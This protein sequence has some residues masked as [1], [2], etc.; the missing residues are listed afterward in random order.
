MLQLKINQIITSFLRFPS[1][2]Q[3]TEIILIWLLFALTILSLGFAF[4]FLE[5]KIADPPKGFI[6][7][8]VRTL[9]VPTTVEEIIAR[10]ILLPR[11]DPSLQ[12]LNFSQFLQCVMSLS[13]Y[14]FYHPLLGYII[15]WLT[16]NT[17]YLKTFTN[18][19]FLSLVVLLGSCCTITYLRT[20]SIWPSIIFHWLAVISWLLLLGGYEKLH[21]SLPSG[22]YSTISYQITDK[23]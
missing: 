1:L 7:E 12:S 14:V 15:K 16:P 9:I 2:I 8:I 17:S 21:P 6:Y 11:I 3:W 5:F 23:F 19:I 10:I 4:K 18:P 22:H 20:Q 13:I